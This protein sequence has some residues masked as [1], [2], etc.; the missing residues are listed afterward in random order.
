[1]GDFKN[2]GTGRCQE[3]PTF[4]CLYFPIAEFMISDRC[5]VLIEQVGGYNYATFGEKNTQIEAFLAE[6]WCV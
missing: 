6:I 2:N 5:M 3:C 4:G 1:M